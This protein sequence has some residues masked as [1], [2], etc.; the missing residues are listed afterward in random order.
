MVKIVGGKRGL[1]I[2][3]NPL[4]LFHLVIASSF[5]Q[6]HTILFAASNE[7]HL[8]CFSESYCWLSS[9]GETVSYNLLSHLSDKSFV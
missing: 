2:Q 9:K 4:K 5:I 7:I 6:S 1:S 3:P 8:F